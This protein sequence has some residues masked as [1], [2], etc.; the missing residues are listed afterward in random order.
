MTEVGYADL[1]NELYSVIEDIEDLAIR[2]FVRDVLRVAPGSFWS[3]KASGEHH[4]E[5]ERGEHGNLLHTVR[6]TKTVK[7]LC[8][9]ADVTGV[10]RD[11]LTAASI[12]HD[13][14]RYGLDDKSDKTVSN[15]PQLVREL[16]DKFQIRTAHNE[17]F[18][19]IEK[20]MG[21][22]GDPP[23][24]IDVKDKDLLHIA[25]CVEAHLLDIL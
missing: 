19:I 7:V 10:R 6:V 22:W 14:C 20:H 12:L 15:H 18:W 8:E 4:L 1:V 11:Y 21:K 16:A 24:P 25:D 17:I 5:D 9:T 13:I 23:Q 3:W 2:D